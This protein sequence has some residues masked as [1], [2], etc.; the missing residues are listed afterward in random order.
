MHARNVLVFVRGREY[1]VYVCV[2]LPC[3]LVTQN[4]RSSSSGGKCCFSRTVGGV[5]DESSCF[6]SNACVTRAH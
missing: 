1:E 5:R 3:A 2:P 4:L 6:G